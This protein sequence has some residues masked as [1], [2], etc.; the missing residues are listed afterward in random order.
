VR[1]RQHVNPRGPSIERFRGREPELPVGRSIEVEIGCAEAHFLFERAAR[2]PDRIYVGLELRDHLVHKV[3]ARAAREG[4]PV[5]AV[6]CHVNHHLERVF[7]PACVA[8]IYIN[9]PDPWFKRRHR[10]RR[11][12]DAAVAES[13]ARVLEPGGDLLFQSDVWDVALD[14]MG[15]LDARDDLFENRAGPWSFWREGN[16]FGARSWRERHCEE[17]DLPIWRILYRRRI[18]ATGRTQ[19]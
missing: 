17:G 8:R 1:R 18:A 7:P 3:N 6:L 2:D 11:L 19:S 16:P 10:Q 14:A 13:V 4:A 12:M 15:V 5:Q 9:F